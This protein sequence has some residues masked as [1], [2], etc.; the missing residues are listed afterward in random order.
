MIAKKQRV[1]RNFVIT[2]TKSA[3]QD[4]QKDNRGWPKGKRRKWLKETERKIKIVYNS[5]K[6]DPARFYLGATAIADELQRRY[7]K[8]LLPPLITIGRILSDLGLSD[9]RTKDKHK[10]AAKYLCYPEYTVFNLIAKRVLELDFIGRKFLKGRT[11]PLNFIAFSFKNPPRL[12][13]FKRISGE[14]GNEV[15]KYLKIFFREFEKPEAVKMDND[16]ALAGSSP[17]SRVI[18]KVPL[19][20]LSQEVIPIF[21]VPRKPFS[22]ASIEG[23]NS[24]FARKFWNR[25]EFTSIKEVDKKLE[26]FN[27]D[28]ERYCHYQKPEQKEKQT[29]SFIP[30]I[31]F[32]RQVKEDKEQT[33][34]AFINVSNE[35]VFL[36]K[37]YINYFVLA[38]WNLKQEQLY[39]WFEKEQ[40]SKMIR[41]LSFK[42]NQR[43]KKKIKNC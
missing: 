41:K 9:K 21:A 26:W 15:I 36:P 38:E 16:F 27:R 25:I 22:Q 17:Y 24:V 30:K 37:T 39:I 1:S 23:N 34:K 31:Y 6:N 5:L 3:N 14:T 20:L 19:W 35:K 12:R 4:F 2:W 43:T 40:K 28:S 11:E 7:P 29:K 42:I 10:G 32:I 8:D 33:G 13:H 18:S